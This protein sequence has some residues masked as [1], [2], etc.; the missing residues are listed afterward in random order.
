VKITIHQPSGVASYEIGARLDLAGDP[1]VA[2]GPSLDGP[3]RARF[4]AAINSNAWVLLYADGET[5]MHVVDGVETPLRIETTTRIEAGQV[6][7]AGVVT[8]T[9]GYLVEQLPDAEPLDPHERHLLGEI[10]ERPDDDAPRRVLADYWL[11]HGDPRG[12]FVH[13]QCERNV[14]LANE[15]LAE[16]RWDH[17][18]RLAGLEAQ[19]VRGFMPT[20]LLG[21]EPLAKWPGLFRAAPVVCQIELY[22]GAHVGHEHEVISV[23]AQRRTATASRTVALKYGPEDFVSREREIVERFRGPHLAQLLD[24]VEGRAVTGLVYA[25]GPRLTQFLRREPHHF[26][27]PQIIEIGVQIAD[28]LVELHALGFIHGAI[29]PTR[30]STHDGTAVLHDFVF[31]RGRSTLAVPTTFSRSN[32][33]VYVAPEQISSRH[34]RA[35]DV[36]SLA[37]VLSAIALGRH[38]VRGNTDYHRLV[39]IRDADVEVPRTDSGL[40][41]VLGR[42][43]VKDPAQRPSATVFRE[44]LR[45]VAAEAGFPTGPKLL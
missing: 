28:A 17:P 40:G 33:M 34:E 7:R 19:F 14:T 21:K 11:E 39:A 8:I 43:L 26:S 5:T 23:P 42:A 20:L 2:I 32:G 30:I 37:L 41:A 18:F 6:L 10:G 15:L 1:H 24:R 29:D 31:A 12:A 25:D 3:W 36:W 9:I 27:E 38:P 22:E 35:T 16:H 45:W 44:M 13:A 4:T